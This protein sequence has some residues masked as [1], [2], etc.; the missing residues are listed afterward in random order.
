[1]ENDRDK[2][3]LEEAGEDMRNEDRE[4]AMQAGRRESKLLG[5]G[6]PAF[7]EEE[8]IP[9]DVNAALTAAEFGQVPSCHKLVSG[10]F[11]CCIMYQVENYDGRHVPR[12]AQ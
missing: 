8:E 12:D 2:S 9:K 1:M 6:P 3:D 4:W 11:T 7:M 10:T 5:A